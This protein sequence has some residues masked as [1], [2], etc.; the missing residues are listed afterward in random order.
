MNYFNSMYS[1][2]L[3][4]A[5]RRHGAAFVEP[6]TT[7]AQRGWFGMGRVEVTSASGYVRRGYISATTGWKPSLMLVHR[8]GSMS[9]SDLIDCTDAITA[10][11]DKRGRRHENPGAFE[12]CL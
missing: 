9:G 5:K 2:W 12:E 10:W 4:T 11:I 6:V 7:P 1:Q 3:E 8:K